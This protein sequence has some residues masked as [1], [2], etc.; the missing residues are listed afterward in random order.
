MFKQA[1]YLAFNMLLYTCLFVHS[2][3]VPN[4]VIFNFQ[5]KQYKMDIII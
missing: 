2:V 5:I 3:T 4:I 1:A